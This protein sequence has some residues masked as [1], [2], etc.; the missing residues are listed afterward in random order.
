MLLRVVAVV[1]V[2]HLQRARL[3]FGFVKAAVCEA[4]EWIGRLAWAHEFRGVQRPPVAH[5]CAT[6]HVPSASR[7]FHIR[8]QRFGVRPDHSS[9][10]KTLYARCAPSS[11]REDCCAPKAPGTEPRATPAAAAVGG[12]Q[13]RIWPRA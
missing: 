7:I 6:W 4:N 10:Y 13:P 3:R 5:Q 8:L 9:N 12:R 1:G 11:S 2:A